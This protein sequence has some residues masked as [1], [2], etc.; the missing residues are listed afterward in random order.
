M[1]PSIVWVVIVWVNK[2]LGNKG[3]ANSG[4]VK[5]RLVYHMLE[6][7]GD[8][9]LEKPEDDF[10]KKYNKAYDRAD[11]GDHKNTACRNIFHIPDFI[12]PSGRCIIR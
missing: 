5:N 6:K 4:F 8:F 1:Q 9:F 11:D 10:G 2:N 3:Y 7:W 12:I